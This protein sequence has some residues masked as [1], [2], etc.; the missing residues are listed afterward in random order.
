MQPVLHFVS[1]KFK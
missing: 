1:I